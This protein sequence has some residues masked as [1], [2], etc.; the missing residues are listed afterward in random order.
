MENSTNNKGNNLSKIFSFVIYILNYIYQE[1]SAIPKDFLTEIHLRF[2]R[3]N[4]NPNKKIL[5]VWDFNQRL[6]RLGDFIIFLENL[7]VLR[8]E[9]NLNPKNKRNIDVC[10]VEDKS[11]YNA[12]QL[13]FSK[14]YQFKKTIRSSLVVNPH[15]DSVLRFRSNKE[16]ERFYQQNRRRYIRWP[17]TVSASQAYDCRR[18]EQF[19]RKN[20]FIPIFKLPIEITG[21][22]YDFYEAHVYPSLPIIVNIRTNPNRFT[23]R[24]SNLSEFKKFLKRYEKNKAYKFIIICNKAEIPEDFRDLTNVIFSKDHFDSV[25]YDLAFVKTGYLSILPG[26]GMVAAAWHSDIPFIELGPFGYW[27]KQTCPPRGKTFVYLKEYQRIY[28]NNKITSKLLTSTF[29]DLVNYLKKNN[30]NNNLSNKIKDT[31]KYEAQF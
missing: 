6:A 9:F 16:F 22:I 25:E 19:Y 12:N 3:H 2:F 23:Y 14:S 13:R 5:G 17:P 20:K 1:M 24:N 4:K 15:I 11:H 29:E 10:F 7:S 26:S 28:H 18:I 31:K 30:L 8:H 21:K 27:A